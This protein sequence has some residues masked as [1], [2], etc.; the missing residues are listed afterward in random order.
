[1]TT[2]RKPLSGYREQFLLEV[3]WLR[4]KKKKKRARKP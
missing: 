1:M 2:N 4:A 3:F